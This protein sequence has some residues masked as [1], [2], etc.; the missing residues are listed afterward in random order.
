[1]TKIYENARIKVTLTDEQSETWDNSREKIL[2]HAMS[3][4]GNQSECKLMRNEVD[5]VDEIEC[6]GL[7]ALTYNYLS[8]HHRYNLT[9]TIMRMNGGHRMSM[10]MSADVESARLY[11]QNELLT[12]REDVLRIGAESLKHTQSTELKYREQRAKTE[13]D[14]AVIGE[15]P[16]QIGMCRYTEGG[17]D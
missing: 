4:L 7:D 14:I 17:N 15:M 6:A 1:M 9:E 12:N 8:E 11:A 2:S 3:V 10:G 5:T 13:W 16:E